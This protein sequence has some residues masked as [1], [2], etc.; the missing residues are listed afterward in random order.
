MRARQDLTRAYRATLSQPES[1][2]A[3]VWLMP[4]V[5]P[6]SGVQSTYLLSVL[7][8]PTKPGTVQLWI[9]SEAVP[10]VGFTTTDTA[11]TI[12][13]NLAAAISSMLDLPIASAAAVSGVITITYKPKGTT[14]EDFP[15][16]GRIDPAGSG[17]NLSLGTLAF[18][19]NATG[20]G[21]VRVAFGALSVSTA[22]ANTDTPTAI[23]AKVVASSVADSYPLT[24]QV[25]SDPTKADLLLVNDKD[26]RRINAAV[27][28]S[29]GTTV[30]LG[31][32]RPAARARLLPLPT[33]VCSVRVLHRSPRR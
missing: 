7:G 20:A 27:I 10:A 25:N 32:G 1:Q 5:A 24:A 21:T 30:N 31:S 29:T 26:V 11:S 4:I 15:I 17:I 19:T 12:A 18:A 3:E 14:G 33:T 6:S 13:T 8:T 2:G 22:I 9:N 23:A 28:T 16:R